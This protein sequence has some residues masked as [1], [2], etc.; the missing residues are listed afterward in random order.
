MIKELE[1]LPYEKRLQD[2]GIF[3]PQEEKAQEGPRCSFSSKKVNTKKTGSLFTSR[4][5]NFLQAE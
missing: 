3:L 4:H 5:T 2:L 1:N